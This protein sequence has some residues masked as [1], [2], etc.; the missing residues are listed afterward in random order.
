[1][2][3]FRELFDERDRN[4]IVS[5]LQARLN[6]LEARIIK[7]RNSERVT[8]AAL[9][10]DKHEARAEDLKDLNKRVCAECD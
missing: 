3:T 9:Q 8:D 7:L 10:L 2:S 5:A 6:I 1:M 4:E